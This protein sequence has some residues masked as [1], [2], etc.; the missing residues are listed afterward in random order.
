MIYEMSN[1]TSLIY[2]I[3]PNF[4]AASFGTDIEDEKIQEYRMTVNDVEIMI[5]EYLVA[6]TRENQWAVHFMHEDVLYMIRIPKV[7]QEEIEKIVLNLR[8]PLQ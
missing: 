1:T 2:V 8:F 6:E 3:K 5:A 4:R 7:K